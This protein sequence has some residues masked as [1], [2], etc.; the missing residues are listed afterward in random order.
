MFTR[1]GRGENDACEENSD[2]RE[3]RKKEEITMVLIDTCLP[4]N[5]PHGDVHRCQ[6]RSVVSSQALM[7]GSSVC[8]NS[9]RAPFPP[10]NFS[11]NPLQQTRT[12]PHTRKDK[13]DR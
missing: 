6:L 9:G 1:E 4:P 5:Y 11:N 7:L 2:G 13:R 3:Q 12:L 8:V 10:P